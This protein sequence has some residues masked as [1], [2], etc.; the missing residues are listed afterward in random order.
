MATIKK[1]TLENRD[2]GEYSSDDERPRKKQKFNKDFYDDYNPAVERYKIKRVVDDLHDEVQ[3]L[4]QKRKK[5]KEIINSLLY[6]G[7]YDYQHELSQEST[8]ISENADS[9]DYVKRAF[10]SAL[11]HFSIPVLLL[12]INQISQRMHSKDEN[13]NDGVASSNNNNPVPSKSDNGLYM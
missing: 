2:V 1:R 12:V 4:N 5:D 9:Y 8:P 10:V 7:G 11:Q 6:D 3:I 13:K